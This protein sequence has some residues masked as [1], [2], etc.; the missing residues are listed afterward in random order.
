MG[1]LRAFLDFVDFLE[2][3]VKIFDFQNFDLNFHCKH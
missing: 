1:C 3:L 2:K